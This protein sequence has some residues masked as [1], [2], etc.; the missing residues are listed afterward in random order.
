VSYSLLFFLALSSIVGNSLEV[1][2][3]DSYTIG[4]EDYILLKKCLIFFLIFVKKGS[5]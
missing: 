1:G 5:N 2:S 3:D 4:G